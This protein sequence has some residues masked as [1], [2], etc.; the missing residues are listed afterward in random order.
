MSTDITKVSLRFPIT[1]LIGQTTNTAFAYFLDRV[2]GL[3]QVVEEP[4]G[5]VSSF[6][7]AISDIQP[8]QDEFGVWGAEIVLCR[9]TP[10][11]D[12]VTGSETRLS[13]GQGV[14]VDRL[15]FALL[16]AIESGFCSEDVIQAKLYAYTWYS[17]TE[18]PITFE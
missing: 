3:D 10:E 18:E 15:S 11:F 2:G 13:E 4:D 6:G 1:A 7:K 17:G 5:T 16:K 8:V 9:C 14:P 12:R